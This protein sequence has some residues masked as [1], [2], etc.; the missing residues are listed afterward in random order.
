MQEGDSRGKMR[1][2]HKRADTRG[3][4][5]RADARGQ[6]EGGKMRA[7]MRESV[8]MEDLLRETS[9]H[10]FEGDLENTTSV[11]VDET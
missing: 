11:L 6:R 3:R 4:C 10:I 7:V 2:R 8:T 9:A 5:E 1:G